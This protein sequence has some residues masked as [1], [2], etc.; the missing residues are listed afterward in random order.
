MRR[1]SLDAV[2]LFHGHIGGMDVCARALLNASA[3]LEEGSMQA[4]IDDRYA[5]W[6]GDLGKKI[7]AGELSLDALAD[8]AEDKQIDPQPRSGRQEWY[9]NLVN[10]FV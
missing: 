3:M 2:D 7:L 6:D 5:G 10:R 8:I 9:E 1:Q 4:A